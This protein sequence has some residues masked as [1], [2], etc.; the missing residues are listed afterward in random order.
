MPGLYDD[1]AAY[2]PAETLTRVLIDP[3][4]GGGIYDDGAVYGPP[5]C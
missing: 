2:G 5:G 3:D 1:G 4:D